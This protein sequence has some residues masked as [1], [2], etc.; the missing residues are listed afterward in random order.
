MYPKGAQTN[1]LYFPIYILHQIFVLSEQ[2]YIFW[3]KTSQKPDPNLTFLPLKLATF[4]FDHFLFC[5]ASW[6]KNSTN[7][8]KKLE[9]VLSNRK[10]ALVLRICVHY[11]SMWFVWHCPTW[12]AKQC[13][14]IKSPKSDCNQSNRNQSNRNQSNWNQ[15]FHKSPWAPWSYSLTPNLD[16]RAHWNW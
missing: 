9:T 16:L 11:A 3:N 15:N 10:K 14:S 1:A 12:K 2:F 8:P 13:Q 4:D 5:T 6:S 7:G